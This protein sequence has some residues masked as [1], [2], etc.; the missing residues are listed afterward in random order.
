MASTSRGRLR[1][2]VPAASAE[3]A[4]I[5]L[6]TAC[7]EGFEMSK[8]HL[9]MVLVFLAF[10]GTA[11]PVSAE[12]KVPPLFKW[13]KGEIAKIDERREGPSGGYGEPVMQ[14]PCPSPDRETK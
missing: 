2:C 13:R 5:A 7:V 14:G 11:V 6:I 8:R 12:D 9:S 4:P 3:R 1:K 10:F